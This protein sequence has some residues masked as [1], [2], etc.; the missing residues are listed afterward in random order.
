MFL[1]ILFLLCIISLN[2]ALA[3]WLQLVKR[4]QPMAILCACW[5]K[6]CEFVTM[7]FSAEP[8]TGPMADCMSERLALVERR[9]VLENWDGTAIRRALAF[10]RGVRYFSHGPLTL[11]RTYGRNPPT[12]HQYYP[13]MWTV[14]RSALRT[15]ILAVHC[16]GLFFRLT[17]IPH[18]H[19]TPSE[20][21]QGLCRK[22]LVSD[23]LI[24]NKFDP[25]C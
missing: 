18:I 21:P 11:A 25:E 2:S 9:V 6:F 24:I 3:S 1:P 20:I 14:R 10:I 8:R 5:P 23:W 15:R 4:N 22:Y 12:G 16:R 19:S 13:I 7:S 17:L